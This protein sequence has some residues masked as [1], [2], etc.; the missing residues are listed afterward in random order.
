MLTGQ[1]NI[2]RYESLRVEVA[3]TS[4]MGEALR[5]IEGAPTGE[6]DTATWGG[7]LD[8][9]GL[10]ASLIEAQRARVFKALQEERISGKGLDQ[11]T[12]VEIK[13]L[14]SMIVSSSQ[15]GRPPAPQDRASE[16]P[17]GPVSTVLASLSAKPRKGES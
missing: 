6:P 14:M 9:H 10:T 16:F 2:S 17:R 5:I 13:R 4:G 1:A 11:A 12:S 15:L 3:V 7:G 8:L